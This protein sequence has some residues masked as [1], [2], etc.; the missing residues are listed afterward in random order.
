MVEGR[1]PLRTTQRVCNKTRATCSFTKSIPYETLRQGW[2][3][4]AR[5]LNI[6]WDKVFVCK[7]CG[8]EPKTIVCD[9][10]AIGFR[11]DFLQYQFAP[12]ATEDQPE[13]PVVT[14][15]K[16]QPASLHQMCKVTGAPSPVFR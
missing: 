9:G 5:R 10:T 4:F 16:A 15:S 12:E 7:S 14:G 2:N 8:P 6:D 11:K 1:E 3:S 13:M